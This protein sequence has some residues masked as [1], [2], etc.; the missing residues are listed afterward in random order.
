[1]QILENIGVALGIIASIITIIFT[2]KP[3]NNNQTN[4][5]YINQ[6]TINNFVKNTY[7]YKT[8]R[9][10]E[11]AAIDGNTKV[12]LGIIISIFSL[13]FFVV[14]LNYI[15][16]LLIFICLC[17]LLILIFCIRRNP[18][19]FNPATIVV[20]LIGI[21]ILFVSIVMLKHPPLAPSDYQSIRQQIIDDKL[22]AIIRLSIESIGNIN[23]LFTQL[24]ASGL[25]C[26]SA[27]YSSFTLTKNSTISYKFFLILCICSVLLSSGS[28]S[29]LIETVAP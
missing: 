4:I 25:I 1:M 27:V 19:A 26:F 28:V 6:P 15:I 11:Y 21:I 2:I 22:T 7:T 12:T 13:L 10:T 23:F 29:T 24:L 9:N 5:T 18:E 3:D 16:T 20:T 14:F 8:P 17:M